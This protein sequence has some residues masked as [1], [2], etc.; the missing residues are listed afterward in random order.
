MRAVVGRVREPADVVVRSLR[1]PDRVEVAAGVHGD[2]AVD[3]PLGERHRAVVRAELDRRRPGRAAVRRGREVLV[4]RIHGVGRRVGDVVALVEHVDPAVRLDHHRRAVAAACGEARADV[5]HRPEGLAAVGRLLHHD[6]ELAGRKA[7][8]PRGI[9][10]IS[11]RPT[12]G[13][14]VPRHVDGP[15]RTDRDEDAVAPVLLVRRH[16]L[17]HLRKC[18]TVVERGSDDGIPLRGVAE[19]ERGVDG[20]VGRDG[21]GGVPRVVVRADRAGNGDRCVECVA[22]VG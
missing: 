8:T 19:H 15:V 22:A 12:A 6:V 2:V 4:A 16:E 17:C 3:P 14:V 18:L 5:G 13:A 7:A 11:H 21:D 1:V 20:A 9:A 10:E